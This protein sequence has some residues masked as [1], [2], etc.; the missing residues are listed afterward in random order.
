[1]S[2]INPLIYII[3]IAIGILV[4]FGIPKATA[5][6]KCVSVDNLLGQ[7]EKISA[8]YGSQPFWFHPEIT[9]A[10]NGTA[11]V[12]AVWVYFAGDKGGYFFWWETNQCKA[13]YVQKKADLFLKKMGEKERQRLLD[14]RPKPTG[15]KGV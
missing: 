13:H 2:R 1:M 8:K 4:A 3:A 7:A 6:E 9:P 12:Y 11:K 14:L 15:A 5:K 10:K